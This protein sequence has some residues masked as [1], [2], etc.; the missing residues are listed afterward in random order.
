[1]TR[2]LRESAASACYDIM[3]SPNAPPSIYIQ[4]TKYICITKQLAGRG[5]I[6]QCRLNDI[7]GSPRPKVVDLS[8]DPW[9]G[10]SRIREP[11]A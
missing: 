10:N 7:S 1:M 9:P 3:L 2:T 8:D 6:Y 4:I 11:L 5:H